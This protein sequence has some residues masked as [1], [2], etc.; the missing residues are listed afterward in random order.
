M[1]GI[2]L[3]TIVLVIVGISGRRFL[4]AHDELE[5]YPSPYVSEVKLLSDYNPNLKGTAGDTNV[6]VYDSGVPGG[7]LLVVGGAHADEPAGSLAAIIL[8]ENAEPI[9]GRLIVLPFANA[10]GF[11]HNLPQEGHPNFYRITTP[12]GD[13]VLKFGSRLTNPVHQWPDPTVYVEPVAHQRLA[14]TEA[15]N[16]NRAYP[17]NPTGNLTSMIA[18]AITELIKTEQVDIAIDM[19]ESSPEYPVNNA[20]VAHERGLEVAIFAS[21]SLSDQ[22]IDVSIE[23]SPANFR[24]LSHREWGDSSDTLA[25]LLEFP[26][27]AQGRL[28]GKTDSSLVVTG[29]D[30]MYVRAAKR[31]RLYVPY[32]EDGV[33]ISVRAAKHVTTV[34]ALTDIYSS[35]NPDRRIEINGIASYEQMVNQGVG[36]FLAPSGAH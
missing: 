18:Y 7:T 6:Y 13:R 36:A 2:T 10:S 31:N 35:M 33:P 29:Q 30:R 15:R 4:E 8:A 3:I 1:R 22:G 17:G 24:G 25:F 26:N 32:D 14:G 23:P 28:R 19:H 27:P 12:S 11:T 9:A 5:M 21:F 16:L 34:L 20:I